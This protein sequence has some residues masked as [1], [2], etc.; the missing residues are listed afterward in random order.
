MKRIISGVSIFFVLYVIVFPFTAFAECTD[1]P[2]VI[3]QTQTLSINEINDV[4]NRL[5]ELRS[6]YDLDVIFV[7]SNNITHGSVQAAADDYFDYNG[8]GSDGILYFV[9][10]AEREYAFSTTGRGIE[11]FNLDTLKYINKKM[12]SA[13]RSG[14]YYEAASV[15]ADG[16]GEV[17][18]SERAFKNGINLTCGVIGIIILPLIAAFI[19]MKA[20]LSA[21]KTVISRE[22][23]SDYVIGNSMHISHERDIFLRSAISK[24]PKPKG[25]GSGVHTS[26]S[27][28]TH[29]GMSGRF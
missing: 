9:S 23:A 29:G 6:M 16:C 25:K 26:S 1:L 28:R 11:I 2:T 8:Y 20:K 19:L 17:L 7:I 3:D 18:S 12:V 5:N 27:G 21:M 14:N 24:I 10:P 22:T 13:L 4:D 15:Y